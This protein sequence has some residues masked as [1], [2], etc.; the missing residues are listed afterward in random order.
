MIAKTFFLVKIIH[1]IGA[2]NLRGKKG[3]RESLAAYR[4]FFA[5]QAT[6]GGAVVS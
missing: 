6:R 4:A 1:R 3:L 2:K 5:L